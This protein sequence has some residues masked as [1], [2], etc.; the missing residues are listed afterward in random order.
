MNNTASDD[1]ELKIMAENS[2]P[3]EELDSSNSQS[4]T[5]EER[6]DYVGEI[7]NELKNEIPLG[8][9]VIDEN[10]DGELIEE[11]E[12][13]SVGKGCWCVCKYN[14]FSS[15][16]PCDIT[17]FIFIFTAF[18]TLAMFQLYLL[19]SNIQIL[20]EID[21]MGEFHKDE[22]FGMENYNIETSFLSYQA[23]FDT[24]SNNSGIVKIYFPSVIKN[25]EALSL[26]GEDVENWRKNLF[27]KTFT[28]YTQKNIGVSEF[29]KRKDVVSSFFISFFWSLLNL[30]WAYSNFRRFKNRLYNPISTQYKTLT[31]QDIKDCI[32]FISIFVIIIL[33]IYFPVFLF[34]NSDNINTYQNTTC[35]GAKD[36]RISPAGFGFSGTAQSCFGNGYKCEHK[37]EL[38]YPPIEEGKEYL[39]RKEESVKEWFNNI[40]DTSFDCFVKNFQRDTVGVSGKLGNTEIILYPILLFCSTIVLYFIKKLI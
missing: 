4:D 32:F 19:F 6:D 7:S 40:K 5:S 21:H 1:V 24:I 22:C 2:E 27:N 25:W 9:I 36:L 23:S 26:S 28:C 39:F 11:K 37:V 29:Y 33:I 14:Y 20:Y 3:N 34:V 13:I 10:P 17:F 18:F 15:C 35:F 12:R 16:S 38:F 8:N 31:I 30:F